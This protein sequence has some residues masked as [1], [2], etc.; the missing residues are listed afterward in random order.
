MYGFRVFALVVGLLAIPQGLEYHISTAIETTSET[1][2]TIGTTATTT[3]TTTANTTATTGSSRS[4]VSIT[5]TST[6]SAIVSPDNN[7]VGTAAAIKSLVDNSSGSKDHRNSQNTAAQD[8]G[9]SQN[10]PAKAGTSYAQKPVSIGYSAVAPAIEEA[11]EDL[12]DCED[13]PEGI[14]ETVALSAPTEKPVTGSLA[15]NPAEPSTTSEPLAQNEPSLDLDAHGSHNSGKSGA[16]SGFVVL[17]AA[18]MF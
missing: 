14:Y 8:H 13:L 6:P 3:L 16:L 17:I 10:T 9:N 5:K 4:S 18:L 12:P 2:V 1:T 7:W 15:L 11:E